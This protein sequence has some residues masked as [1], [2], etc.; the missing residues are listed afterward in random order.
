MPTTKSIA[1]EL[2]S[3]VLGKI[4]KKIRKWRGLSQEELSKQLGMTQEKLSRLE[5]GMTD[6][7]AKDWLIFCSVCEINPEFPLLVGLIN[8]IMS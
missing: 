4:V 6:M 7:S 2:T 3:S 8:S 5:T 1:K